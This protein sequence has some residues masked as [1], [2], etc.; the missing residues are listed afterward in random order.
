[1]PRPFA[2]TKNHLRPPPPARPRD[3]ARR[4]ALR[5]ELPRKLSAAGGGAAPDEGGMLPR[6]VRS[7][8]D[9]YSSWEEA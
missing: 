8:E 2:G 9:V 7:V 5:A 3:D 1:M 6:A 4:E